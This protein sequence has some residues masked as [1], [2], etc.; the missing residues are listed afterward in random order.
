MRT[1]IDIPEP[2]LPA[3]AEVAEQQGVSRT[4]VI[5]EAVS[6]YLPRIR[7]SRPQRLS[8]CGA[9]TGQKECRCSGTSGMGGER[10]LRHLHPDRLP[11][12][13]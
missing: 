9:H 10:R 11:A 2:D 6:A 7:A 4:A 3:V 12:A 8:G 13:H 1:L 5:R